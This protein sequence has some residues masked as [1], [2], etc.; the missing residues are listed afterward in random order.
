MNFINDIIDK[1]TGGINSVVELIKEKKKIAII[2]GVVILLFIVLKVVGSV[3]SNI[4]SKS[5]IKEIEAS[6]DT[7]FDTST[8]FDENLDAFTLTAIREN[9][10]KTDIEITSIW[11]S[12]SFS[13]SMYETF[14][15]VV[16]P[17][18]I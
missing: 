4:E 2:I 13:P 5:P 9:G 6:C 11:Q 15:G 3:I 14:T 12:Y 17:Y 18:G 16:F 8:P 10:N 7:E 1:I